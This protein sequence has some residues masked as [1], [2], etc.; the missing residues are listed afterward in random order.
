[1]SMIVNYQ[2]FTVLRF[3]MTHWSHFI[4]T[5]TGTSAGAEMGVLDVMGSG[6]YG[7]GVARE[8][9]LKPAG[10]VM[11]AKDLFS[12]GLSLIMLTVYMVRRIV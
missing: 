12:K 10:S 4:R 6:C 2:L 5:H 8:T 7:E 11:I 9:G 1:M 3:D